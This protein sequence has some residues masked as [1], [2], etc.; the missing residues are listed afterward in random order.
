MKPSKLVLFSLLF[1][2]NQAIAKSEIKLERNDVYLR[3]DISH[4]DFTVKN[5]SG[6][7]LILHSWVTDSEG[8]NTSD[9]IS[10]P[11]YSKINAD[12]NIKIKLILKDKDKFNDK[13]GF[14]YLQ[15]ETI[16]EKKRNTQTFNI[17]HVLPLVVLSGKKTEVERP[18]EL[19]S[20]DF[21]DEEKTN[22]ITNNCY[23]V[24]RFHNLIK[25]NDKEIDFGITKLLP[26]QKFQL[27]GISSKISML[28]IMPVGKNSSIQQPYVIEMKK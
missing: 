11:M 12:E 6:N 19:L 26:Y 4:V 14:Y 20:I 16:G 8:K 15:I 13:E 25:V 23:C 21:N 27:P 2:L 1:I 22:E 5:T 10:T 3:S 7:S 28:E 17:K 9:I 18:W 24:V